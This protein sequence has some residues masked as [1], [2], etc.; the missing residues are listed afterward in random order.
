MRKDRAYL[1][2]KPMEREKKADLVPSL[3]STPQILMRLLIGGLMVGLHQLRIKANAVPAMHS[4][5][6]VLLK[7]NIET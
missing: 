5:L 1:A 2:T 4:L 3:N 6:L 7:A